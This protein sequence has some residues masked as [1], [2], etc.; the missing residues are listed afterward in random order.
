[1]RRIVF[2]MLLLAAA[3]CGRSSAL[4]ETDAGQPVETVNA[5]P[6]VECCPLDAPSCDCPHIGGSVPVGGLDSCPRLCDAAPV[7]WELITDEWGCAQW[8][9]GTASCNVC[10]PERD[11]QLCFAA[12]RNC[13]GLETIDRCGDRRQIESCGVCTG[14]GVE[15][16]NGACFA[17]EVLEPD[18]VLCEQIEVECG[19]YDVQDKWGLQRII[20]CGDCL[21]GKTCDGGHCR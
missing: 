11:D 16:R 9:S 14:P 21:D 15:C 7:G 20:V 8:K 19:V 5:R 10:I 17:V 4:D 6:M 12:R 18:A 2:G 3:A 13:G 1:M